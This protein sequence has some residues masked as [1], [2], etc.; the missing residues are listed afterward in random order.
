MYR[1]RTAVGFLLGNERR[2]I[3]AKGLNFVNSQEMKSAFPVR[4]PKSL[5][6]GL[7]AFAANASIAARIL[8]MISRRGRLGY[9]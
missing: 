2:H 7:A 9:E 1:R 6:G 3:I 8:R 4:R 5:A